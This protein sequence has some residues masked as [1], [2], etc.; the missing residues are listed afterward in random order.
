MANQA[1]DFLDRDARG[2][3]QRDETVPWLAWRPVCRVEARSSEND[4]E[5]A[6]DASRPKRCADAGGE[7]E[8]VVMPPV[9]R[10]LAELVL[11]LAVEAERVGA[12]LR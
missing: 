3:H 1:G 6:A 10:S 9:P 7:H 11:T 2:G 8:V 12:A 4:A 5:R